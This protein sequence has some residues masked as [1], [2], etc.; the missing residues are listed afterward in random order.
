MWQCAATP[1]M[2]RQTIVVTGDGR[3]YLI[4]QL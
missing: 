1:V 2:E 3:E 4:D